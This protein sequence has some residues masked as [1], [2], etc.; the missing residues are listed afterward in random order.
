[1]DS[2]GDKAQMHCGR[3]GG[4]VVDRKLD[5]VSE[6]MIDWDNTGVNRR[7]GTGE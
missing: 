4:W 7:Q 2:H 6:A 3:E 5:G 1:M